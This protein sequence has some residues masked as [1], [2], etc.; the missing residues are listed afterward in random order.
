MQFGLPKKDQTRYPKLDSII[1]EKLPKEALEVDR[2][3][4]WLQNFVLD[5]V[6][7]LVSAYKELITKEDPDPD[8]I[9][10]AIQLSLH[11]LGNTSAQFSQERRRKALSCLNPDLKSLVEEKDFSKS[12][13]YLFG[14]SF[15]KKAKEMT[16][17]I[18]CL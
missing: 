7:L 3:F 10:Q 4:S 6:G 13:P 14:P 8:Q 17:A 11:I 15:E 9:Q 12:S 1:K 5:P 16:E 18:K 2:K